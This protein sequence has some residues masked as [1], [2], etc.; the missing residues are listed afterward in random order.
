MQVIL[1][2]QIGMAER[3]NTDVPKSGDQS[4]SSASNLQY[5]RNGSHFQGEAMNESRLSRALIRMSRDLATIGCCSAVLS[6]VF[7][8]K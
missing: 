1:L 4:N 2:V 7:E 6:P 8:E 5:T 3:S